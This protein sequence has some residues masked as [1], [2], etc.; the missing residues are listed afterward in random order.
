MADKPQDKATEYLSLPDAVTVRI[1]QARER[2]GLSFSDLHKVTGIS[3]TALHD[4]ES[5]RTKPGSRELGLL[6]EAMRVTPNWLLFGTEEPFKERRGLKSLLKL[7]SGPA[8]VAA[9]SLILPI[10]VGSFGEEELEALLTLIGT[11]L[12]AQDK[13]LYRRFSVI[14]EIFAELMG[15]GTE[16]EVLAVSAKA[17]E[18]GFW[19]KLER[20]VQE[21]ISKLR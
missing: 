8:M 14:A 18:P 13:E 2:S 4:Y 7:R 3:R 16:A 1:R 6:C 9:S 10:A 12:E 15:T 20:E 17:K 19:D 11:M 5:G 21:R